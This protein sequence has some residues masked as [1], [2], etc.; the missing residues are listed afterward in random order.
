MLDFF[1]SHPK[2]GAGVFARQEAVDVVENNIFWIID[3]EKDV[4]NNL[5]GP[6]K[7]Y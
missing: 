5:L 4:E 6:L 3:R 7:K 2:A 1:Y